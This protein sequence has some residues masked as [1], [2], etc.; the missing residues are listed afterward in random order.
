MG[1]LSAFNSGVSIE[2]ARTLALTTM[3]FFQFFQAF[4]SRSETQSIFAMN[5]LSNPFLLFSIVGAFFAHLAI[6]YVPAFQFIFK[7][8]PLTLNEG[9]KIALVALPVL[10]VVVCIPLL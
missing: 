8:V 9:V 5:P 3:V 10:I 7:T 2:K 4:N 1:F 6:L